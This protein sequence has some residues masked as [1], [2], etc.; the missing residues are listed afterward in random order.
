MKKER[1]RLDLALHNHKPECPVELWRVNTMHNELI[2]AP[3]ALQ[4]FKSFPQKQE[5]FH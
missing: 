5:R 4:N 2:L 1:K 3:V